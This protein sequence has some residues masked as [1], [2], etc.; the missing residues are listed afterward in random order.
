MT[1]R[2]EDLVGRGLVP[3]ERLDELRRVA[4]NFAVALT[5]DVAALIDPADPN[6]PIA[7][8]YVPRAAELTVEVAK[9]LALRI[10]DKPPL[11]VRLAKAANITSQ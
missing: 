10:A 7:A 8:Q 3:P 4:G 9:R 6:D 2:V 1:L 5:E 11:A